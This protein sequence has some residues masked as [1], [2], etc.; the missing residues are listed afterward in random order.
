MEANHSFEQYSA[1]FG[2]KFQ[3]YR[4]DNGALNTGSVALVLNLKTGCIS[5][6]L[7][8]V[9]DD[10]FKI[11]TA[12]ITNKIPD[13][14]DNIFKDHCELPPE[15]FQLSIGKQCKTRLTVQRETTSQTT[16]HFTD[17]SEGDRKVINNSPTERLE[18]D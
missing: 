12:R 18:G 7:H 8:I 3:K 14:W 9:F 11:T 15:E 10:S 17:R 6:Q 4:A 1:T 5:P 2:V 16:T 13:S